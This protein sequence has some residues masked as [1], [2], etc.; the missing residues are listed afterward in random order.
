MTFMVIDID[1]YNVLLGLDFLIK[2]GVIMDVE[3]GLIQVRH[4]LEAH[5]EI[6]PVTMVNMLQ[7]MNLETLMQDVATTLES[8]HLSGTLNLV[9]RNP[10]LYDPIM[11]KQMDALVSNLN[12]DTNDNEHYDGGL[13]WLSRMVMSMSVATP[14]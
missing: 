8:T 10:S 6:L 7:I 2:I 13:N 9:I 1:N 14:F 11:P 12:N 5:V 4:G 3:R